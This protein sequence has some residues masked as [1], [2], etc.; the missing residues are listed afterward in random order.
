MRLRKKGKITLTLATSQWNRVWVRNK[1]HSSPSQFNNLPFRHST[2]SNFRIKTICHIEH[3][4]LISVRTRFLFP[5][6]D[7][8]QSKNPLLSNLTRRL[9]QKWILRKILSISFKL[10]K[11]STL[12]RFLD[13]PVQVNLK[14]EE[15]IWKI[16]LVMISRRG[17]FQHLRKLNNWW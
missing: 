1:W 14:R 17:T 6:E 12:Q 2:M 16:P 10:D 3:T 11:R 8:S 5:Q 9:W 4:S 7:Y 13:L 15:S